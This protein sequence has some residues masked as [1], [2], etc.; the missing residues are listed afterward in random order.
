M[1]KKGN[2]A[3]CN[4]FL[5]FLLRINVIAI[6]INAIH[7]FLSQCNKFRRNYLTLHIYIY[8]IDCINYV[9]YNKIFSFTGGFIYE[10]YF[11]HRQKTYHSSLELFR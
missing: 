4:R 1:K 7:K 10:N 9:I 11:R 6:N 3:K 8:I 5:L 2:E